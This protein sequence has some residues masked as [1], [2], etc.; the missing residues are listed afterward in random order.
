MKMQKIEMTK[1]NITE[2]EKNKL[3][4]LNDERYKST[5]IGIKY[6]RNY[7]NLSALT[8]GPLP[9]KTSMEK[10]DYDKAMDEVIRNRYF[11][12]NT[13]SPKTNKYHSPDKKH[14]ED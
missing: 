6:N 9:R 1:M 2:D 11:L 5:P 13:R 14:L 10:H 8:K 4:I 3:A 7:N 12:D